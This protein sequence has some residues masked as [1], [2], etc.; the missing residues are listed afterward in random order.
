MATIKKSKAKNISAGPSKATP[1]AGP[2]D[3]QGDWTKIQERTIG[4]MK[5]GG[6]VKKGMHKMPDG[7]MMKNSDMKKGGKLGRSEKQMGLDK[8]HKATKEINPASF[9]KAQMSR[10]SDLMGKRSGEQAPMSKTSK[11][12]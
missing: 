2:I 1:V 5:K 8:K 10:D 6:S 7:S 9:R 4:N 12:K 11:K 3:A